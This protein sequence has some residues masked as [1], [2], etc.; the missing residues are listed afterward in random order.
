MHDDVDWN[1]LG[2]D[3]SASADEDLSLL[4]PPV[5]RGRR[6]TGTAGR[7]PCIDEQ[8][9]RVCDGPRRNCIEAARV[10]GAWQRLVAVTV[11]SSLD[12]AAVASTSVDSISSHSSSCCCSFSGAD[13]SQTVADVGSCAVVGGLCSSL[14]SLDGNSVGRSRKL[15]VWLRLMVTARW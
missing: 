4:P 6:R 10:A 7:S 9:G 15:H 5:V 8:R 2:D 1:E 11:S 3:I 14:R 13:S 12:A